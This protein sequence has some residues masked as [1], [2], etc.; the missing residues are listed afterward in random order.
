MAS[1]GDRI[2]GLDDGA[3]EAPLASRA[4]LHRQ[5][6]GGRVLATE[7][8]AVDQAERDQQVE[9]CHAQLLVAGEQ[10]DQQGGDPE[11]ADGDHR[12]PLAPDPVGE[13]AEDE[14]PDRATD[15]GHREDEVEDGGGGGDRQVLGLEVDQRR[16]QRDDRQINVVHV[17][18]EADE[19]TRDGP[20]GR[21]AQRLAVLVHHRLIGDLS[22][23][24]SWV[25]S[26]T[27]K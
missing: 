18:H 9:R 7:E 11:A 16:R 21:G 25:H 24:K 26:F 6:A 13:V 12:R 1:E 8:D 15:Q 19:G 22:Q 20:L 10:G 23:R 27:P 2:A 17:H 4:V 3:V 5:R 14:R